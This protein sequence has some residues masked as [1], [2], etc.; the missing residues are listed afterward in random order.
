MLKKLPILAGLAL[1]VLPEAAQGIPHKVY[2]DDRIDASVDVLLVQRGGIKKKPLIIDLSKACP[3]NC[4]E[5]TVVSSHSLMKHFRWEPGLK[6][7][8]C[9]TPSAARSVEISLAGIVEWHSHLARSANAT[10]RFPFATTDFTKDY[11]FAS[12]AKATYSSTLWDWEGNYWGHFSPRGEDFFSVSGIVGV[13]GFYIGEHARLQYTTPPDTSDYRTHTKNRIC[14][15]QIGGCIQFNP[16]THK[17]WSIELIP[18]A[19]IL[20]N[21]ANANVWIGDQ[22]NTVVVRSSEK[23]KVLGTY[24]LDGD[25]R[26]SYHPGRHAQGRIGYRMFELWNVAEATCQITTAARTR[27]PGVKGKEYFHIVYAGFDWVF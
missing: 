21:W 14:G 5:G 6:G 2:K 4:V 9:Y 23:S 7:A 16:G 3:S 25:V 12:R 22:N 26:L 17:N 8:V 18:K 20:V 24:L 1:C 19:G 13:R 27:G 15:P 10:L 11:N